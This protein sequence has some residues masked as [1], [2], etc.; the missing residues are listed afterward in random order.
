MQDSI[1][2][3]QILWNVIAIIPCVIFGFG[4]LVRPYLSFS[5]V[6]APS[7]TVGIVAKGILTG[8]LYPW[9]CCPLYAIYSL[10]IAF[11]FMWRRQFAW[12]AVAFVMFGLLIPMAI[13]YSWWVLRDLFLK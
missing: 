10:I 3:R 9:V 1:R 7:S 6:G 13:F 5:A 8:T 2:H 4:A 12:S 11:L